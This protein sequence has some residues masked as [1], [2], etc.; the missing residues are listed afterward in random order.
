MAADPF[1]LSGRLA[2]V[3][4]STRGIGAG[5]ARALAAAG[6]TV[7]VHGRDADKVAAATEDLRRLPT[8]AGRPRVEGI[9][10]DVTAQDAVRASIRALENRVGSIDILVNNAGIN[11]PADLLDLAVANWDTILSTNLTSC[12]L[13]AQQVAPGMIERGHGKIINIC[14]AHNRLVRGR[15]GAYVAAKSG[16]GG[17]TQV[18]CA[19]WAAHGIQA[20]GLAPGFID[21]DMTAKLRRNPEFDHW[22]GTRTPAGRWG[23]PADLGGTAVWLASSASDFVNGQVIFVDGGLTAVM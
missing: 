20:N 9:A 19:S 17:L 8:R 14:S 18:M 1:D 12:F 7:V 10:F 15:V 23:T 16:L 11:Y 21:T 6:A 13:L 5:I 4:G 22:I 3:T 2:L